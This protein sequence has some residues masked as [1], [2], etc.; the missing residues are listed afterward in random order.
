[1]RSENAIHCAMRPPTVFFIRADFFANLTSLEILSLFS[2]I[3]PGGH[4]ESILLNGA[5]RDCTIA[6]SLTV[7]ELN[8]SNE[9][10]N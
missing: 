6:L 1:M 9:S 3:K 4:S 8:F 10:S 5:C 2:R 7:S